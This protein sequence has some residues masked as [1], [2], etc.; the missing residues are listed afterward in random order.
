MSDTLRILLTICPLVFIAG[1]IDSIAGGGGLISLPA[2]LAAGIPPHFAAATNKCS[3]TFG[4]V[5]SSLK[6]LKSGKVHLL[7]AISA[8]LAA[9]VGST[10]GAKINMI[11]DEEILRYIMIIAV[12]VIAIFL[13][14]KKDFGS[15]NRVH[16]KSKKKI[17]ILSI[18]IGFF[19]GL[20]DGFFGPGTGTFLILLFTAVVG[21][22]LLT[23][24][25]N[26]KIVNMASNLAALV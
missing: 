4:T 13:M 9:L 8:A 18:I 10:I 7:S 14:M 20:Y 2:Y 26:T 24:S 12:P 11:I 19:I 16:K 6:F 1:F 21:F 17:I 25:G 23:A 5:I 3:S 22:D 15:V